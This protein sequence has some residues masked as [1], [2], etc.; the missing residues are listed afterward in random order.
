MYTR[1][2]AR[3]V[4]PDINHFGLVCHDR[5]ISPDGI[6]SREDELD[7]VVSRGS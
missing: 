3:S 5:R 4:L 1:L 2:T 7:R 6:D